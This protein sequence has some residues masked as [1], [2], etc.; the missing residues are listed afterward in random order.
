MTG[1][2]TLIYIFYHI[3]DGQSKFAMENLFVT[4]RR[5]SPE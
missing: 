4:V 3:V 5:C 2:N 1:M